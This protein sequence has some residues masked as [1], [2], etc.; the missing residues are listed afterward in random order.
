[1]QEEASKRRIVDYRKWLGDK[2]DE[3]PGN[4]V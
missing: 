3:M 2:S 1:M 4:R